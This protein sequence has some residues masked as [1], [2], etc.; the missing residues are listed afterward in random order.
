LFLFFSGAVCSYYLFLF[1]IQPSTKIVTAVFNSENRDF[2]ELV[3]AKMVVWVTFVCLVWYALVRYANS[4]MDKPKNFL[5]ISILILLSLYSMTTLPF[6][7]LNNYFPFQYLYSFSCYIKKKLNIND[8][9]FDISNFSF[10]DNAA[11]DLDVILVVGES[12]RFDHFHFNG[13]LRNTTPNL[14]SLTNLRTFELTA[15]DTITYSSLP[16]M[17]KR[18]FNS[19]KDYN[20][21]DYNDETT[22]LSIFNKLGFATSWIA[23]QSILKYIANEKVYNFYNEVDFL[24]LPGGSLLYEM[25]ALDG[26]LL[27]FLEKSL[28]PKQKKT[29]VLHT[30]GSHWDYAARYS[31]EFEIYKPVCKG[32]SGKRDYADC[33][34]LEIIN[35]YD[36]S[37][38]YTDYFLQEVINRIKDRNAIL[39]YIADHGE[40][41][42]ENGVYGHGGANIKEQIVVP[43][44]VWTSDVFN[45]NN[46]ATY[47]NLIKNDKKAI[48][49]KWLFHSILDCANIK[50]DIIDRNFSVCHH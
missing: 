23:S 49:Y 14:S 48:S 17:I 29:I 34:D 28:Q 47:H 43:F 33:S 12:A 20:K 5:V 8:K 39:I 21:N 45:Q 26:N 35:M 42:G 6:K 2:I 10:I 19:Q 18:D 13:Y 7:V 31:K 9:I 1:K 11:K 24:Q 44:L 22:F 4:Q 50:S 32:V 38:L 30:S 40:S 27:D 25:N 37:I 41:L 15:C 3:S 46:P 36:N 16:C